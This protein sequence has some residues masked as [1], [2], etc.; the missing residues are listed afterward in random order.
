MNAFLARVALWGK[1]KALSLDEAR[2]EVGRVCELG[3]GK[4]AGEGRQDTQD[5]EKD[6]GLKKDGR[7]MCTGTPPYTHFWVA[8]RIAILVYRSYATFV[9]SRKMNSIAEYYYY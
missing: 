9:R 7:C 5:I 1:A 3:V 6:N 4:G 8:E 2:L